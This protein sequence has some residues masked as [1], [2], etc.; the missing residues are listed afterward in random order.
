MRSAGSWPRA[1]RGCARSPW[2]RP[3]RTPAGNSA[4]PPTAPPAPPAARAHRQPLPLRRPRAADLP[5]RDRGGIH[6]RRAPDPEPTQIAAGH[7]MQGL[8]RGV[9]DRP[10]A[11]GVSRGPTQGRQEPQEHLASSR[12]PGKWRAVACSRAVGGPKELSYLDNVVLAGRGGAGLGVGEGLV[13][14][15]LDVLDS[16]HL[17]P[18]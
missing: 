2:C 17:L 10:A 16:V 12:S 5:D 3:P 6:L 14:G 13:A 1:R 4:G 18:E 7:A 9:T 8:D 11:S 15:R